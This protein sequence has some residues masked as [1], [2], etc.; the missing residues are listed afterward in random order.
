MSTN[1][2]A[3]PAR[4]GQMGDQRPVEASGAY[5]AGEVREE[6]VSRER[7]RFGG[8]KFGSAFFGWLTAMGTAV[9]LTALLQRPARRSGWR[10]RT[11]AW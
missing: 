3:G 5:G 1:Y 6:V 11:T 7:E 8:M 9:L 10:R 4:S 2:G